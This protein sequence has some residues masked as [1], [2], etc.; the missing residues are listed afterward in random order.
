MTKP[1]L[2][3]V[4]GARGAAR[5]D[6]PRAPLSSPPAS[7]RRS[8]E[9]RLLSLAES[10]GNMGHWYWD[11]ASG[12]V[13]CSD[14]V[15]RIF[16]LDAETFV[17]SLDTFLER[18]HP[19]EQASIRRELDIK[20]AQKQPF[21]FDMRIVTPSGETRHIISRGQPELNEAGAMVAMIGVATDVTD[22]FAAIRSI[23]DQN[24][25]LD[26]AAEMA[27]L[28]HW[29]WSADDNSLTYCSDEL[30]RIHEM[31]AVV[32][33]GRFSDP[34]NIVHAVAAKDRE[35]YRAMIERGLADGSPYE[36]EYELE[37]RFATSK[38][39]REIGQP[40]FDRNG[41][42]V[43]FV[44]TVQDVTEARQRELLLEAAKRALESQAEALSRSETKFRDMVEGSIQGILV[45]RGAQIVFAN[46][47][48]AAMLGLSAPEEVVA[49]SDFGKLAPRTPAGG[50]GPTDAHAI[51]S[52]MVGGL[53]RLSLTTIERRTIWIDAIGRR[54]D[55]DGAP[56][57][58]VTVIEVTDRHFA[59]LAL[60]QKTA[61]LEQL[62]LQKDKLFSIIAHD[63]KGPFNSV[64]GFAGLLAAKARTLPP[65]K[66][67]EYA[68]LV[69]DSATSVHDLLDNLLA[70]ASVQ[71]RDVT[72]RVGTID[73]CQVVDASLFPLRPMAA[74]KRVAV[75]NR[76]SGLMIDADENMIRIVLRNLISNGIKFTPAEGT[77]EVSAEPIAGTTDADGVFAVEITVRDS[78]VGMTPAF[79]ADLFNFG[80]KVSQV[81]TRGE[82]GTG[83]G[84]YLCRDIISRH[85]GTLT[86]DSTVG[87][88]TAFRFT[89][90]AAR[91]K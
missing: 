31:T 69:Y 19:D 39:I 60:K 42:L 84:L 34:R 45:M 8:E 89:L 77:V 23:Q 59:E 17:P 66:I 14:Q 11:I 1:R 29:V 25:M 50:D 26:L 2:R 15:F 20:V 7:E 72:L 41:R 4:G 21:E 47:A 48:F 74:E 76:V 40:I 61:E 27:H 38:H 6:N 55:W 28:G 87:R 46:Q 3:S 36:I 33:V 37:T 9:M 80:R 13:T 71:M 73:L 49:L 22:A 63:L 65:E 79:A 54:I 90:P 91:F 30:A 12:A 52:G 70:W 64:L 35:T 85:G 57:F 68:N 75:V 58:L 78:G 67:A 43:R 82:R 51:V 83:L 24:E 56:A 44:A 10:V 32:F 88:G 5:P 53:T 81:G 16:G 86:V 62:N 18:V